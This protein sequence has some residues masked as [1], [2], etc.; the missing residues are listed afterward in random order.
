MEQKPVQVARL[1]ELKTEPQGAIMHFFC[2]LFDGGIALL[3]HLQVLDDKLDG[4]NCR[5][6]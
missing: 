2:N 3:A 1:L 5:G 6:Q 4:A